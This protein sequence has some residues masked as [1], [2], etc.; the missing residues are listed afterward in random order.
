MN[1]LSTISVSQVDECKA[2]T[3]V[4]RQYERG[5]EE[6]LHIGSTAICEISDQLDLAQ[7]EAGEGTRTRGSSEDRWQPS[8]G[9]RSSRVCEL[10]P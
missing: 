8:K 7:R 6:D 4:G 3:L 1:S 9:V 2:T 5:K 10:Q